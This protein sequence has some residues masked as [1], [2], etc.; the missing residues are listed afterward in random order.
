[1]LAPKVS[2]QVTGDDMLAT[3][4]VAVRRYQQAS[5]HTRRHDG[6]P[7]THALC[8]HHATEEKMSREGLA[9]PVRVGE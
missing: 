8:P 6:K 4:D 1:M 7:W 9:K 2:N 3:K 5:T